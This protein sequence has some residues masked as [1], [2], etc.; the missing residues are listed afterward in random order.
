MITIL[1][2]IDGTLI[3][4]G[5]AGMI[6][7]N[8]VMNDMFGISSVP[9]V[10]VHG[11][12]DAG[13]LNDIFNSQKLRFDDHK[14]EF[15]KRYWALLPETLKE[16]PGVKLPGVDALLQRLGEDKQF[17]IGILTGNAKRAAEVKLEH[18]GLQSYFDFGGYGDEHACRNE[19]AAQARQSAVQFVG[20]EKFDASRLWVV[21][22]T[23]NDIVCARSIASRVV[24]V[25]TG[26]DDPAKLANA[27]PDLQ[28]KNLEDVESF[29]TAIVGA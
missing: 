20:A 25:E 28:C 14:V 19:V 26:G 10:P 13:I 23:V 11:R 9:K 2:D 17:A 15:S 22:D 21:G 18:F 12:T 8:Q 27:E 24:A 6:A 3:R 1:F 29:V 7:I 5:G 16:C 4:S